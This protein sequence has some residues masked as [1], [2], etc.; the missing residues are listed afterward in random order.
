[1]GTLLLLENLE[2]KILKK[3]V[4]SSP[5][6]AYLLKRGEGRKKSKYKEQE[7]NLEV[8]VE[9]EFLEVPY[10]S[11]EKKTKN[12]LVPKRHKLSK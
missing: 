11:L 6:P 9:R 3:Y 1:M 4:Y 7:R 8:A 12:I 10:N 5:F 2:S